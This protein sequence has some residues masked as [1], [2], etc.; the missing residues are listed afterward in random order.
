VFE[1]G[2]QNFAGTLESYEERPEA[3]RFLEQVPTVWDETYLL[4]GRPADHVVIAR[5]SGDR[6]F[7]GAGVSGAGRTLDVPLDFL[8]DRWLV[9][10]VRDGNDGLVRER[11]VVVG[12]HDELSVEVVEE[13]GFAAIACPWRPGL[14]TC[15]EPVEATAAQ[16][17]AGESLAV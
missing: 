17:A 2:M 8:A 13:G 5:R 15:D 16:V 1:S 10:V 14:K 12:P 6:W 9:E 3:V 11:R 7:L 4:S